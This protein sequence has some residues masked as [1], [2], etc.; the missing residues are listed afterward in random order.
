VQLREGSFALH[1]V[2]PSGIFSGTAL[3]EAAR[4]AKTYGNSELRFSV[5]QNLYILGVEEV[6]KVLGE[7]FFQEYKNINTPYLNNL[8]ACVGTKHCAFG[9][10]ENKE[11]AKNI[12]NYLSQR[13]L[14]ENAR[15][16]FHWSACVKGCGLHGFG[17]IGFEGCKAKLDGQTVDGVHITIGVKLVSKGLVGYSVIKSPPLI[18]AP[19]YVKTLMLE[20]KNLRGEKESFAKFHDLVLKNYTSTYDRFSNKNPR[21]MFQDLLRENFDTNMMQLIEAMIGNTRRA[22][23][24]S[25]LI[26]YVSLSA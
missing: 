14:L 3:M 24:F 17:D 1:V 22:K 21:E 10:I 6:E 19:Q 20:Y 2:V 8:I 13:V 11:D 26:E 9:V 15:I 4:I 23:V 7:P 16:R 12:A 18:Y 5:E 25:E